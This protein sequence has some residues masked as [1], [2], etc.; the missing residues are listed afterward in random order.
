MSKAGSNWL[1]DQL[2]LSANTAR[3]L[4]PELGRIYYVQMVELGAH[5]NK[6]LCVVAAHLA[7]RAW[8][9]LLRQESYVLRDLDGTPTSVAEGKAIVAE[10]FT[11]PEDIRRRRRTKKKRSGKAPQVLKARSRSVSRRDDKR[12]DL[13]LRPASSSAPTVV[14]EGSRRHL[15]NAW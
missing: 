12:G 1:R 8:V 2:V 5:P 9:T 10:H 11:V 6:A 3:Q 13:P 15:T 7:D 14:K 4:G